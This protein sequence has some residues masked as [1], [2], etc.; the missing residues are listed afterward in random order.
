MQGRLAACHPRTFLKGEK[1]IAKCKI[2]EDE[3][4][5]KADEDVRL[6]EIVVI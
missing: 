2:H 5:P 3:V 4:M 1:E 6:V